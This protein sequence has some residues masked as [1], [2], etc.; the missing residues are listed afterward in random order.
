TQTT[1]INTNGQDKTGTV[2]QAFKDLTGGELQSPRWMNTIAGEAAVSLGTKT[3]SGDLSL[4][5]GSLAAAQK[6]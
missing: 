1:Y 4:A 3:K 5:L 6:T 2:Q